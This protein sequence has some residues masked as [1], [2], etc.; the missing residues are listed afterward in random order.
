MHLE[1]SLHEILLRSLIP[2]RQRRSTSSTMSG[3]AA[4]VGA[5]PWR[6]KIQIGFVQ[7]SFQRF[8]F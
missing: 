1:V 2:C 5:L 8:S 4:P 7:K 6:A 3:R